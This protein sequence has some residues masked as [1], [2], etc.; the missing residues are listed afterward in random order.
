MEKSVLT[1][2]NCIIDHAE[3]KDWVAVRAEWAGVNADLK[4]AMVEIGSEPLSQ[5][6]SLGGW[7]RGAEAVSVLV[8]QHYST[9]AAQLLA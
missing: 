2:A 6:V 3:K 1:R 4:E 9:E 8:S 7:L 5:L